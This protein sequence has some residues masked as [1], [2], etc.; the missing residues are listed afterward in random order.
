MIPQDSSSYGSKGQINLW[1]F[2][3]KLRHEHCLH[4]GK[5]VELPTYPDGR[6]INQ[7]G[8]FVASNP[9]IYRAW[10]ERC[11]YCG[12]LVHRNASIVDS[13]SPPPPLLP[14]LSHNPAR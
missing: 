6:P 5:Y 3:R 8:D 14:P 11:C 13:S 7:H 10:V 2:K 12:E 4:D 9:R 1:P